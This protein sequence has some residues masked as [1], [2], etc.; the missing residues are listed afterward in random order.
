MS[1]T[2][3]GH[4]PSRGRYEIRFQGHL[5]SRWASWFEGLTVTDESG[6]T[7]LVQGPVADQAALH[8]LLRKL[9][10]LGLPLLSVTRIG[11]DE[12]EAPAPDNSVTHFHNGDTMTTST[13]TYNVAGPAGRL[14]RL[15]HLTARYRWPVIVVWLV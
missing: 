1:E 10:D 12:P 3:T 13:T 2:P 8:G 6:G 11:P 15:A 9:H 14:G 4:Q 7:T 5:H